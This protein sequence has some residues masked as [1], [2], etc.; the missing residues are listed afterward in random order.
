MEH[1][2]SA[3]T[4]CG[5]P[6]ETWICRFNPYQP[7]LLLSGADDTHMKVHPHPTHT[8]THAHTHTP[9]THAHTHTPT[10]TLTTRTRTRTH[11]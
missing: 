3:H 2:W 10:L 9:R 7:S 1:R 11:T 8:R 6:S 5:M 4:L